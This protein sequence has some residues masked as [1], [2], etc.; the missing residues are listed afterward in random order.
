MW[1]QIKQVGMTYLTHRWTTIGIVAW[2]LLIVIPLLTLGWLMDHPRKSL[3]SA[4]VM[5]VCLPL[6]FLSLAI[7]PQAKA[8]FGHARAVLMPGFAAPHLTV[9]VGALLVFGV[10]VPLLW[11]SSL[12][13][14]PLGICALTA[15]I[16]APAIWSA[17]TSGVLV[18]LVALA[19]FYSA[20]SQAGVEW[21]LHGASSNRAIHATILVGCWFAII[22]WLWRLVRLREE[23]SDYQSTIQWRA[24]RKSGVEV[25]EQRRIVAEQYRR[26]MLASWVSDAWLARMPKYHHHRLPQIVTLLRYGFGQP[27][28]LQAVLMAAM[29]FA[30]SLFLYEFGFIP[31]S[32]DYGPLMFYM[33]MT[34]MFPGTLAMEALAQRR[35]RIAAEFVFPITRRRLVDGLL[36]AAAWN[37]AVMWVT[38]NLGLLLLAW[39]ILGEQFSPLVAVAMLVM[40]GCTTFVALG[41]GFRVALW[42]SNLKR[43]AALI[44]TIFV[45]VAVLTVWWKLFEKSGDQGGFYVASAIAT[46]AL[47]AIGVFFIAR[48]R[49]AWRLF[50]LG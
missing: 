19:T 36:L 14:D 35:P 8:Q 11:A 4:A 10:I 1:R 39:H 21:W 25:P 50:E 27:A 34:M 32:A 28:E 20:F 17:H 38:M 31:K 47:V 30:I 33:Q 18:M 9:L 45:L 15:A 2:L 37:A 41:I 23:M 13:L 7:V 3:A 49:R 12:R 24:A 6:W 46:P 42:E 5:W 44:G 26:N 22:A 29:F 40:T 48:A 16:A 43:L